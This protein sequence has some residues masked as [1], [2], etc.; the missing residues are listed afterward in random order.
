[1]DS[2]V[3][4]FC[5]RGGHRNMSGKSAVSER[6]AR[7]ILGDPKAKVSSPVAIWRP[8]KLPAVSGSS[9]GRG[10]RFLRGTSSKPKKLMRNLVEI[11]SNPPGSFVM[12]KL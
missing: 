5:F 6:L 3:L 11:I 4:S 7:G 1:M 8:I 9:A 2:P 12:R 10:L